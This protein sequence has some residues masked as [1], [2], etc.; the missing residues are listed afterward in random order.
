MLDV[1][2][3]DQGKTY[4]VPGTQ[5]EML[6]LDWIKLEGQLTTL[7]QQLIQSE[8]SF[9][10]YKRTVEGELLFWQLAAGAGL[11]LAGA[12]VAWGFSR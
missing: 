10:T 5:L 6:R 11:F 4:Q 9:G 3:F 2:P 8:E 12:A 7:N 1:P